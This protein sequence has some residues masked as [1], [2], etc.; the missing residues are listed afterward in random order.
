M[1][2][3]NE[4]STN[5]S[6]DPFASRVAEN[7]MR[8]ALV[9]HVA[10]HGARA[11]ELAVSVEDAAGGIEVARWF[12]GR[13]LEMLAPAFAVKAEGRKERLASI[14]RNKGGEVPL[15]E[16]RKNHG[17]QESEIL[18]LAKSY[19]TDFEIRR[20]RRDGVE[21]GRTPETVRLIGG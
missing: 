15:R 6:L 4:A 21:T 3:F 9:F 1:I 17:F 19:P 7:A 5:T 18:A 20:E 12:F 14:L 11:G 8:L 13:T 2:E 10:R 16:M